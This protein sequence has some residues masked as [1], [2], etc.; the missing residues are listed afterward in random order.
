[1]SFQTPYTCTCEL[2][3]WKHV[4]L[5]G[6]WQSRKEKQSGNNVDAVLNIFTDLESGSSKIMFDANF[7]CILPMMQFIQKTKITICDVPGCVAGTN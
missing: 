1:M 6:R 2:E 5:I 3:Y 7:L 4:F